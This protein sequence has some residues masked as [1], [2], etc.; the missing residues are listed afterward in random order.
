MFSIDHDQ[1]WCCNRAVTGCTLARLQLRGQPLQQHYARVPCLI[2]GSLIRA[3]KYYNYIFMSQASGRCSKYTSTRLKGGPSHWSSS[4]MCVLQTD[5]IR[6]PPRRV[7]F[8]LGYVRQQNRVANADPVLSV[9]LKPY[10]VPHRPPSV[11]NIG[12]QFR[13]EVP[14]EAEVGPDNLVGDGLGIKPVVTVAAFTAQGDFLQVVYGSLFDIAHLEGGEPQVGPMLDGE[15][16]NVIHLRLI[17]KGDVPPPSAPR[18]AGINIIIISM[19][20][21][22]TFALGKV[23]DENHSEEG[24][25]MGAWSLR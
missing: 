10:R 15:V 6:P 5:H 19:T 3:Y 23:H 12:A 14:L 24:R 2:A 22:A 9:L 18:G 1:I 7:A 13:R 17:G 20:R 8:H 11:K 16:L 21:E 4:T 25:A